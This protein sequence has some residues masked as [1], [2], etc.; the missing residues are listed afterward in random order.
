[1]L[2][3]MRIGVSRADALRHL[4]ERTDVDELNGF[5]LAMIQADRFGV[6]VANVLRAQAKEMRTKRRQHAEE[7]AQRLPIN[8][9]FPLIFCIL[10][11]M[12]VVILGPGVIRFLESFLG[13]RF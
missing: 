11:A 8:L 1:M 13:I 12:F 9:L 6:S 10:P 5:A 2:Q 3:E 4:S 7:R